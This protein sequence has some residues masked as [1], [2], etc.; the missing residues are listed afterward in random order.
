MSVPGQLTSPTTK[1]PAP[2][3][4][5]EKAW[6]AVLVAMG[7][8]LTVGV[9]VW[10][11]LS[12]DDGGLKSKVTTT[13]ETGTGAS[14]RKETTQTDYADTVVIFALTSGVA[15]MLAGAFF[16]RL[17]EL[18]LG[19]L[20]FRVGELPP[21]K[22][23]ELDQAVEANVPAEVANR[24]AVVAAAKLL[25]RQKFYAEYWGPVPS[26][27]TPALRAIARDAAAEVVR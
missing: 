17:R 13:I 20:S 27:P 23:K 15:L 26:P 9:L 10:F 7:L 8:V 24:P 11:G 3:T 16:G 12:T 4:K 22:E 6:S 5:G 14:L 25:A 19:G 1:L 21:E 18:K 2:L